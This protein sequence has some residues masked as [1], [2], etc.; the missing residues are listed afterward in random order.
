MRYTGIFIVAWCAAVG[1]RADFRAQVEADWLLQE[2]LRAHTGTVATQ[3][4]AAGGCDGV[5]NGKWGFHTN[6]ADSPWWQVDLGAVVAVDRVVLWNRCDTPER[7]AAI[8]ILFSDDGTAWRTVYA[9]NGSVFYGAQQGPPLTVSLEHEQARFV[10]TTIP[11]TAYLHLDEVEVFG[12]A[13]PETNLALNHPAD[14]CGI[15]P[16]SANHLSVSPEW[17]ARTEAVIAHAHAL[18]G[19][20]HLDPAALQ[21]LA[22]LETRLQ[23]VPVSERTQSDYMEARWVL[24]DIAFRNPLLDFDTL[25][26]VKR[27]P[28][29]FSHMSD[30]YYGWWSRPGGGVYLL[31]GFGSGTP[32]TINGLTEHFTEPG[33]FLRPSLSYDGSKVLFAWCKHY[34]DLAANPDKLNKDHVPEDAFYHVFEMNTDGTGLHQLTT[35]KYDDF[36]ARYLPNGRIVF[37]STRRG[38]SLQCGPDT[39]RASNENPALPDSYVRCGGGPERPVAVYT[40]HTMDAGGGGLCAISPFEMFEWTPSIANDGAILYS[41]WDYIDRSNMPYMGLWSMHPDGTNARIV[42]KNFTLMPH[43]TFEPQSIPNS[44]KI[45]FTGSGHHAQTMGGLVLLDPAVGSEG[46]AAITRLT[47]EVVFPE[48]EGWPD[49]FY[50]SPWPLSERFYLVAWGREETVS[51]GSLRIPNGM[52][53]YLFDADGF[54]ELLYRDP[55]IGCEDPLPVRARPVPP[56]LVD[57]PKWEAEKEGRFVV[58]DVYRGLKDT[59]RGTIKSLRIVAVPPKTHPTMNY[60]NLGIMNDDPGKCVLGTVPVEEDG[61]AYFRVPSSLIV[62][63]QAL[64]AR[65]MAVQTMRSITYA[66]PGQTASCIGCHENRQ[67]AP[68]SKR[69]MAMGREPSRLSPGP[70]GSWPMR[71]DRLVQPILDKQCV[72][73]HNPKA[74]NKTAAAFDLTPNK[75]YDTLVGYGTPSLRDQVKASYHR[76]NSVEGDCGAH[77]SAVLKKLLDPTGHHGVV[78]D[79]GTLERLVTWLDLYGQRQGSFSEQQERQLVA[80]REQNAALLAVKP[81]P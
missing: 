51:Q 12:P 75:A 40:L 48:I 14:Q 19:E 52:G 9:H 31:R 27:V 16:W 17:P 5:K 80:L 36:D 32:P 68:H 74:R 61:S 2:T 81:A 77:T 54:K 76:G 3:S 38:Q 25:L 47:P 43:C 20:F 22:A 18:A 29:S 45:V 37:L 35:G 78:L 39:A 79:A 13:A 65:G 28:G 70:D 49:N 42:Y 33:S 73:C 62:F 1:A 71:F 72:R 57:T 4:D 34:P 50:T 67:E 26:F 63:F 53:L 41:R 55:D 11:G 6:Q 8:R 21:P 23:A 58:G 30:Q 10:R 69:V 24:R 15:S 60:P 46:T 59:P 66:Q 56:A 64:D 7:T 44:N